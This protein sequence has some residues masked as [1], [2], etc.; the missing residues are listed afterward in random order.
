MTKFIQTI[1]NTRINKYI[2]NYY[3][4]QN[5]RDMS[6]VF[7]VCGCG[8]GSLSYST[9]KSNQINHREYSKTNTFDKSI[10]N[11]EIIYHGIYGGVCGTICGA[12]ILY[13]LPITLPL[14]CVY[15]NTNQ[16]IKKN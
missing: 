6:F 10:E 8:L 5:V 16:F 14:Y 3:N 1:L 2:S 12:I 11:L 4:N 9:N 7:S 13:T 15:I